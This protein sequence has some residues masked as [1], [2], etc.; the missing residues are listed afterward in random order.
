MT[1]RVH[2]ALWERHGHEGV[3]TASVRGWTLTVE[4]RPDP[5]GSEPGF[6]WKAESPD[7]KTIEAPQLLEEIEIAMADAEE[8]VPPEEKKEGEA[9]D[10]A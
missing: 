4:W 3:Y 10:A 8:A 1:T 9:A 6:T 2:V 5:K 7:G